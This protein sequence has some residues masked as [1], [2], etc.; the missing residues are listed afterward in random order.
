MQPACSQRCWSDYMHIGQTRV[1]FD[2]FIGLMPKGLRCA[3]QV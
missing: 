2:C 3:A 1:F